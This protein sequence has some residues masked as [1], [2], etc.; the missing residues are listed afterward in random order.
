MPV[1]RD[2][3][4]AD[5]ETITTIY[6]EAVLTGAGSYEIEPPTMDEMVKRFEAFVEQGFPILVAEEDGR[7]LGYAYA[8]YF[9]VRPAYRWLAEDSI[10]IARMRRERVSASF[11]CGNSSTVLL[12]WGSGNCWR[13]S[14]MANTISA[15]SSC[16]RALA[17]PI[18]DVSRAPASSMDAGWIRC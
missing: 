16:M 17:S 8:S 14:A 12:H 9:R 10:Y 3:Q 5:I 4:P 6:T 15:R 13:S 7:V 18:A 1:I 11:C 2:F